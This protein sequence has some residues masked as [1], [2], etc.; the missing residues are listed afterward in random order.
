MVGHKVM[1]V[2]ATLPPSDRQ[3]TAEI[4]HEHADERISDKIVGYAHMSRIMRREHDLVPEQAK[5]RGRCDVP[6]CSQG[7]DEQRKE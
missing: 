7:G 4:G 3:P 5:K 1:N 6:S 2:V